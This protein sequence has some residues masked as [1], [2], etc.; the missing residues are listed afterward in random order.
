M[1][2]SAKPGLVESVISSFSEEKGWPDEVEL[3]TVLNEQELL[4][5]KAR[6]YSVEAL[7]T[8]HGL[9]EKFDKKRKYNATYMAPKKGSLPFL[10]IKNEVVN[11][12]D[13]LKFLEKRAFCLT[14]DLN[15]EDELLHR[16]VLALIEN[17]LKPIELYFVWLD[18]KNVIETFAKFGHSY[19]QPLQKLLCL[20]Q[21][22]EVKHYLQV[23]GWMDKTSDQIL[24]E[25]KYLLGY[26][27]KR[28]ENAQYIINEQLTEADVYLYG[29]L[30]AILESK[31]PNNILLKT[32]EKYPKLVNFCLNFSQVHLGNKAMLWEFL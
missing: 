14:S 8:V 18:E 25:L 15:E 21:Y 11:E 4:T 29:H 13:I 28:L 2:I 16:G 19:P 9:Q 7:L 31:L 24:G 30:Q 32:L 10:R 5:D 12:H 20:E 17:T 22:S 3:Y 23:T 27:S 1:K 26:L 6:M